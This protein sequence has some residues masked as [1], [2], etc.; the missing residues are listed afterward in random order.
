M[1]VAYATTPGTA[2][3][4]VDYKSTAGTLTIAA[5][6]ST[7]VIN[8][9]V[10]GDRLDDNAETFTV[11]LSN[12]SAG[13]TIT[14]NE[15]VGTITDDDGPTLSGRIRRSPNRASPHHC[16]IAPSDRARCFAM[17]DRIT[18]NGACGP[19]VEMDDLPSG[20]LGAAFEH[21]ITLDINANGAGWYTGRRH[22][23]RAV[24]T[25]SPWSPRDRPCAGLRPQRRGR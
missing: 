13:A 11:T 12:A 9:P 19:A 5:G 24:W 15:A 7:G 14:R 6:A 22:P 25:C 1:N 2:T 3:K 18:F 16:R 23:Q 10:I 8:V 4:D 17:V 20:Q 21:T